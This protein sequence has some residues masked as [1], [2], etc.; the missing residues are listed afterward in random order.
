MLGL[1]KG[2]RGR[3]RGVRSMVGVM[4]VDGGDSDDGGGWWMVDDGG[5]DGDGWM[6]DD[7]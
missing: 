2:R 4:V 6:I 3:G 7:E 5:G 1:V